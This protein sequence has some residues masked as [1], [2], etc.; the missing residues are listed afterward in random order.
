MDKNQSAQKAIDR[1]LET[2]K[3]GKF[4]E[5]IKHV[6]FT[7]SN[8]IPL[9]KWSERNRMIAYMEYTGD[10]RG[11]QQWK[12]AGRNVKKG[13]TAIYILAPLAIKKTVEIEDK[14]TGE[15]KKEERIIITGFRDIPVFRMED[16]EG[17]P[18]EY[19]SLDVH[20]L[21]F[22]EVAKQWDIN[23]VSGSFT[24]QYYGYYQDSKKE[25]VMATD[26]EQTF[27]HELCHAAHYRIDENAG[28]L[29]TWKKEIIAELSAATILSM[30]GKEYSAIG[31]TFKYI[32]HYAGKANM[33]LFKAISEVMD[34]CLQVV[35]LIV[36]TA[37]SIDLAVAA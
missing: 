27:A 14:E 10:A 25:I 28:S 16:T 17:K 34:T 33:E 24:G 32:S 13:A 1:V 2:F 36:S 30:A 19:S 35:K 29:P 6:V 18:I 26:S 22:N 8:D 9:A 12:A 31:D 4:P 37:E 11:F 21:P 20:S 5:A 7:P 23:I 15:T 3:K